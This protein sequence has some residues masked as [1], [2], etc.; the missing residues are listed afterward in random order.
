MD[1]AEDNSSSSSRP[2]SRGY[3]FT[4]EGEL[5]SLESTT[6]LARVMCVGIQDLLISKGFIR[7]ARSRVSIFDSERASSVSANVRP[8]ECNLRRCCQSAVCRLLPT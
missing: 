2:A 7:Y 3:D 5:A 4:A 8:V 6:F 1:Q